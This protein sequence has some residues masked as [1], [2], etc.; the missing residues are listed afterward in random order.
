MIPFLIVSPFGGLMAD[1]IDRRTLAQLMLLASFFVTAILTVL[2]ISG[3]VQ[4]WHVAV[5]AFLGGGFRAVQE[6]TVTALIPNQVP[7]SVLLNAITLNAATRHGARFFGLLIAAPLMAIP[8]MGVAGVLVL[9]ALLA[10]VSTLMMS[11]V[12]TRES[13]GATDGSI[14]GYLVMGFGAGSL[15]GI[16]LLAGVRSEKLKGQLLVWTG[17]GSGLA[18]IILALSFN[19]PMGVLASAGMGLS[20]AT[21][22]ALTSAY[23]QTIAPD[24]LRGR[25][26]SLYIL[27]AG[28]IMAFANLGYGF[29]ADEFSAPPILLITGLIFI[30]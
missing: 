28:G 21:F 30:A 1:R 14:L 9:S 3:E 29:A 4:L 23:V 2:V 18:P 27:F 20:Q 8:T 24:R 10:G 15:V 12:K 5:L 16:L 11:L 7:Q 6:P 13:L 19:A 26:S 17:L 25:I 22:M